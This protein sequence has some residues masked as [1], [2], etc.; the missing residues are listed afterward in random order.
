[1]KLVVIFVLALGHALG[2][3]FVQDLDGRLTVS[4]MHN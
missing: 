2:A 1:M 3:E 4:Y